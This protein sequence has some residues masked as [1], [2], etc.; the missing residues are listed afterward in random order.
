MK[1]GKFT[2][3]IAVLLSSVSACFAPSVVAQTPTK[4]TQLNKKH[5]RLNEDVLFR[6]DP[7]SFT[8]L[9]TIFGARKGEDRFPW[10]KGIVTTVFWIGERPTANNPVPFY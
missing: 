2:H 1:P 5:S 9:Q 6:V 7:V 10:K 4:K 8:P 3:A